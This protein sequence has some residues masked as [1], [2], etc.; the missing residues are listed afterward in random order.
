VCYGQARLPPLFAEGLSQ[1]F[2]HICTLTGIASSLA[3]SI[4]F[5]RDIPAWRPFAEGLSGVSEGVGAPAF[6]SGTLDQG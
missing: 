2:Q 4:P 1:P 6:G 3:Q 5:A